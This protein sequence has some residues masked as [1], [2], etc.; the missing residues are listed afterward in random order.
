MTRLAHWKNKNNINNNYI[1][2]YTDSSNDLPLC[3][4]ADEVITVNADVLLAQ[5]AINNGWKQ[6]RWDLNQ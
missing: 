1:Y 3:Y 2:F 5:I 6:S 4:Q